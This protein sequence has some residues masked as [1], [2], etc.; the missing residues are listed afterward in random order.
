[1]SVSSEQR[2]SSA[3]SALVTVA[4]AVWREV[5]VSVGVDRAMSEVVTWRLCLCLLMKW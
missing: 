4:V 3:V 5:R 2:W 1:M